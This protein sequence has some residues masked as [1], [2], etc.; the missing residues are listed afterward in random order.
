M[1]E[2]M[3]PIDEN[4]DIEEVKEVNIISDIDELMPPPRKEKEQ[5][6]HE[7][8]PSHAFYSAGSFAPNME[9]A[10]MSQQHT[11]R[12]V[13]GVTDYDTEKNKMMQ[14]FKESVQEKEEA[15]KLQQVE[16]AQLLV[17]GFDEEPRGRHPLAA[18]RDSVN[19]VKTI[20][21][22][23]N[24]NQ[25]TTPAKKKTPPKDPANKKTPPKVGRQ[26]SFSLAELF[27]LKKSEAAQKA[28]EEQLLLNND[29][30]NL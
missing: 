27:N 13:D 9:H 20:T 24:I 14:K 1:R 17:I 30:P 26:T 28:T 11:S 4:S 6:R 7:P 15:A 3:M 2:R 8:P 23:I 21:P 22:N 16:A 25:A 19:K 10:V 18:K 29:V 12:N 5:K